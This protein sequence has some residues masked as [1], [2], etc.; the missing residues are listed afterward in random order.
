MSRV[1]E[2]AWELVEKE[3]L[4]EADFRAFSF[5]NSATM[6]AEAN[7]DFFLGTIIEEE[8]ARLSA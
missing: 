7:P 4:S 6:W 8:V 1:L 3:L 5:S 2:E